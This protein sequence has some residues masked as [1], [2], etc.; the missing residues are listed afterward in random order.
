MMRSIRFLLLTS[1]LCTM[2][3]G[4]LR[5]AEDVIVADF[6]GG[7]FGDW[8]VTG[9]AFGDVPATGALPQQMEVTG[10]EGQ[11]Y[12]SS[13]HGGDDA[14]GKARSPLWKVERAYLNFLIGG[15]GFEGE[16][17]VQLVS[18]QGKVLRQATGKNVNPGGSERLEWETW[19]LSDLQG[20]EV[21]LEVLDRRRGGWGHLSVDHFQQS[22]RPRVL[23][24]EHTF[25]VTKRYL[26]W[27]VTRDEAKRQRFEFHGEDG[28]MSYANIALS[29][30]PD[31]WVFSDMGRLMG[32][33]IRVT[34]RIPGEM[35]KAWSQV[36][37]SDTFPGEEVIY[38]EPRRPQYHFTSRRGWINDPNGLVYADGKW[39][40]S[41]Q[42]NPYNIFWDNM[43]WGHAVS[44]DLFHWKEMP[45]ALWP[46]E[47]GV[48]FSGSGFVVPRDQS[49]LPITSSHGLGFAYT[50]WGEGSVIPGKKATQAMAFSNDGG[51][52]IIK[53]AGNPVIEHIVGGNRDPKIFWYEP[54]KSWVMALYHDGDEYG[55]HVSKDLV[56]WEQTSTYHIPGDS[57]CP[58]LFPLKVDGDDEKTR[59]VVWGANGVY[60]LGEFD[61]RTF[62]ASGDPQRHYWGNV[63]AGQSYDH[64]PDGRR[65]H[66]GWMRGDIAAFEGAPF[67]LQMSLPMDFSLRSFEGKER[68]WIEPS[69][70]VKSLREEIFVPQ[71][72][73]YAAGGK[74]PL[75]AVEGKAFEIEA[76]V[77]VEKSDAARFGLKLFGESFV[78]DRERNTFSGA[79]GEQVLDGGKVRLQVFSDVGTVEI[80]VNGTYVARYV[81]QEGVP[82]EVI[83]EGGA[84]HF[85]S[86]AG[87]RMSSAWK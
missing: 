38:Q 28:W 2:T 74:N 53:F 76:V 65:V 14:L 16:T 24:A 66:V 23:Q 39:H 58:D 84:V 31:F 30:K 62:T 35:E 80:F 70:E 27:P 60:R 86:L 71:E 32:K 63:Y 29:E 56:D 73:S 81:R 79:E 52:N 75:S 34:G 67:S 8:K 50:A 26:L 15:G 18:R 43:T 69:A 51:R 21:R 48:M 33:K 17:C 10:F 64:A 59:W 45:P 20:E 42:H 85:E 83:A 3:S 54:T 47:L 49:A 87:Y 37:L 41:Y 25:E 6:D 11:G 57:E 13:Y 5:A 55:I 9:S 40:L 78:W 82:V 22:E 68:L 77:D 7:H 44:E 61:G 12:L 19:D 4:P 46:D 72:V 36:V 1:A